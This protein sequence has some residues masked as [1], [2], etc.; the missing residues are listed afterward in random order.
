MGV[1]VPQGDPLSMMLFCAAIEPILEELGRMQDVQITA[2][3]DDILIAYKEQGR[4]QLM[5]KVEALTARYGLKV[6]RDKCKSTEEGGEVEFLGMEFTQERVI[7]LAEKLDEKAKMLLTILHTSPAG[8]A[9]NYR[10]L[11]AVV[12]SK[13]NWAPL[14]DQAR[15]I[16]PQDPGGGGGEIA[17]LNQYSC[18][19]VQ[20]AR[21]M[22]QLIKDYENM[23][24]AEM[25]QKLLSPMGKRGLEF[26]LP[27]AYFDVMKQHQEQVINAT[28]KGDL[29]IKIK[30][31]FLTEYG[32]APYADPT[33]TPCIGYVLNTK[34]PLSDCSFNTLIKFDQGREEE[35]YDG[36]VCTLCGKVFDVHHEMN[37]HQNMGHVTARHNMVVKGFT[38]LLSS[39]RD[40]KEGDGTEVNGERLFPDIQANIDGKKWALDVKFTKREKMESA[41]EE[42]IGKYTERFEGRVLPLIFTYNGCIYGPSLALVKK[43]LAEVK[44]PPLMRL[45]TMSAAQ[46]VGR[47][48]ESMDRR[49]R[50]ARAEEMAEHADQ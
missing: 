25:L 28:G 35:H 50:L 41:Y 5:E 46:A 10:M 24:D 44:L 23:G 8:R 12:V 34:T 17:L 30:Q 47:A 20:I 40:A 18:I 3:A 32:N 9:S 21:F 14:V 42:K 49:A 7:S 45:T 39:A 6:N 4:A 26:I 31:E 13:L 43:H 22:K 37:C 27:G 48:Q 19:D 15:K 1:G 38:N 16:V 2:Y 11:R 29:F 36:L 33:T